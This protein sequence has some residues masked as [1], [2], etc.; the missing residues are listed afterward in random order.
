MPCHHFTCFRVKS[1]CSLF[2]EACPV[3]V[4]HEDPGLFGTEA[5]PSSDVNNL[6][7]WSLR[8]SSSMRAAN[9][10]EKVREKFLFRAHHK[11]N[12][13]IMQ[14]CRLHGNRAIYHCSCSLHVSLCRRGHYRHKT[15]AGQLA[16]SSGRWQFFQ[17]SL[18]QTGFTCTTQPNT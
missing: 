17:F 13:T 6:L 9:F 4:L 15:A 2:E 8:N 18:A 5:L 12:S 3:P 11:T 10:S 14:L 7:L 1:G 16:N